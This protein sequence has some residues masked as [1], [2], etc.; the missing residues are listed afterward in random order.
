MQVAGQIY[1]LYLLLAAI[2]WTWIRT[3]MP[4]IKKTHSKM[5]FFIL[6]LWYLITYVFKIYINTFQDQLRAKGLN[7]TLFLILCKQRRVEILNQGMVDNGQPYQYAHTPLSQSRTGLLQC[8]MPDRLHT[9]VSHQYTHKW[10]GEHVCLTH[11]SSNLKWDMV[12]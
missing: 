6:R 4:Y 1:E 7:D 9:Q 2:A 10:L 12:V 3:F 8:R 11:S 5:C